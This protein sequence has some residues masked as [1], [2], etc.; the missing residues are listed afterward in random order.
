MPKSPKSKKKTFRPF[1][2]LK[3]KMEQVTGKPKA[4]KTTT[5]AF[6]RHGNDDPKQTIR[7]PKDWAFRLPSEGR[8]GNST[9]SHKVRLKD[10]VWGATKLMWFLMDIQAGVPECRWTINMTYPNRIP[11]ARD[12][13]YI[14][15][16]LQEFYGREEHESPDIQVEVNH[17]HRVLTII[18]AMPINSHADTDGELGTGITNK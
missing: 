17:S 5:T 18:D 1:A 11:T 16:W 4:E 12:I 15:Q 9:R 14:L 2:P 7:K 8:A 10:E 6:V 13:L 3:E